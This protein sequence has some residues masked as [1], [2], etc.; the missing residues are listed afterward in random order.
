MRYMTTPKYHRDRILHVARFP[1]GK[2]NELPLHVNVNEDRVELYAAGH[3]SASAVVSLVEAINKATALA[4]QWSA[5]DRALAAVMD[6]RAAN[7]RWWAD[8][9]ENVL[10]AYQGELA[11]ADMLES[12]QDRVKSVMAEIRDEGFR[13]RP[14]RVYPR[15]RVYFDEVKAALTFVPFWDEIEEFRWVEP[16]AS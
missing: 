5:R 14:Q 13:A 15:M 8:A 10:R 11:T 9:I 4:A 7:S 6:R 3:W 1:S 2:A 16:D 12:V